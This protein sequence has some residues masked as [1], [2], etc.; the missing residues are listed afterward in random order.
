MLYELNKYVDI[1]MFDI[2]DQGDLLS[3]GTFDRT[4]D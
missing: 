1:G 3:S 4:D 2:K